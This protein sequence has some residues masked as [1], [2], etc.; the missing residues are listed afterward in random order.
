[1]Y[2]L[3]IKTSHRADIITKNNLIDTKHKNKIIY[4][5]IKNISREWV[6]LE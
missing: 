4:L 5:A 3:S 1:M 2:L 6:C